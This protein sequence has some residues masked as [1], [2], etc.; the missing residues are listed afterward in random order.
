MSS[1]TAVIATRDIPAYLRADA[2][3]M[4]RY[5]VNLVA[6][7]LRAIADMVEAALRAES[8]AAL[9]L[10][11]A[12]AESGLSSDHLGRLVRRGKVPNVGR[13]HAPRIA[14]GALPRKA[15][16]AGS[17]PM[18]YDPAA[19]ARSLLAGRPQ[20]NGGAHG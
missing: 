18:P 7:A 2:D 20:S 8:D 11:E 13:K 1:T 5:G 4:D 3:R 19:D 17:R 15:R 6:P 9:T 12:A 16:V 10:A 14:R